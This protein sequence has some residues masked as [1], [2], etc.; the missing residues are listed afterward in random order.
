MSPVL[1]L[2]LAAGM[3]CPPLLDSRQASGLCSLLNESGCEGQ[4]P[5]EEQG[6]QSGVMKTAYHGLEETALGKK[7]IKQMLIAFCASHS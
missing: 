2:Q 4:S 5:W 7:K 1:T 6:R 3:A